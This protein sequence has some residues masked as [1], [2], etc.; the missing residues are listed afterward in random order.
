MYALKSGDFFIKVKYYNRNSIHEFSIVKKPHEYS[1]LSRARTD[2]ANFPV[3]LDRS[4]EEIKTK[5]DSNKTEMNVILNNINEIE[6]RLDNLK[7]QP[8]GT[9][10]KEI[11]ETKKELNRANTPLKW[12]IITI[13]TLQNELNTLEVIKLKKVNVVKIQQ[14]KIVH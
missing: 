9:V 10:S 14:F 1:D 5:I 2:L 13:E 8:R 12:F 11:T 4:I 3:E 7:K 6:L